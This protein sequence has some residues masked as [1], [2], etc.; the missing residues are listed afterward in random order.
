MRGCAALTRALGMSLRSAFGESLSR[1]SVRA[2]AVG[3]DETRARAKGKKKAVG[4]AADA[5]TGQIL[6]LDALVKRD[7]DAFM[8]WLAD[9]VDEFGVDATAADDLNAYKPI[10]ERLGLKRQIWH[11]AG[12]ELLRLE[13]LV[14]DAEDKS[15]RRP[16][17]E[18]ERQAARVAMP[19]TAG[20]VPR[21]NN[22]TEGAMGGSKAGTRRSGGQSESG[23]L[24]GFGLT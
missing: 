11:G 22:M 12:A 7:S 23:M 10:A 2:S 16:R 1:A 9:C 17:A 21:T 4:I 19:P 5:R 15:I 8:D 6:G 14:R 13:R 3:A 20:D 18:V 24:N